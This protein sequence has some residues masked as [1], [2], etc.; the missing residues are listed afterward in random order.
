MS[1]APRPTLDRSALIAVLRWHVD[2]G[3]DETVGDTPVDRFHAP[4]ATPPG[5][6]AAPA[7]AQIPAPTSAP[8]S[9]TTSATT[10]ATTTVAAPRLPAEPLRQRPTSADAAIADAVARAAQATTVAEVRE[11]L[12][13][14][15]GCPLKKTATNLVF[16]RGNP[17]A[18]VVLVGEAPGAE[19]DRM[20]LAF[21][22]PSGKLL[23][24][25]LASIGLD[26]TTVFITNTVFWRPPGNREP[27]TNETAACLP[28]LERLIDLIDPRLLL[29]LGGPAAKTL[30]GRAESVGKMRGR[31]FDYQSPR[32]DHPIPT[33]VTYHPA[34]LLRSPGQK[35]QAWRDLLGVRAR[36][37][38]G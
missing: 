30:T 19:E 24:R 8:T 7:P 23:D 16:G 10:T 35:R 4:A 2:A 27:T 22:G 5:T 12:A 34:Y 3:V 6:G 38:S 21:V 32:L 33:A 20:G 28:F 26:E 17:A 18:R 15:D 29:A 9:A 36:L 13:A 14:F 37:E 1:P 25:M 11:A 31:W